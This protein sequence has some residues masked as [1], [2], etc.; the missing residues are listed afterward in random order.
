MLS[1]SVYICIDECEDIAVKLCNISSQLYGIKSR[2]NSN[3]ASLSRACG[4][5]YKS[6]STYYVG[7]AAADL[8]KAQKCVRNAV[9]IYIAV[10]D[11]LS[12][13]DWEKHND[14]TIS[15]TGKIGRISIS[16]SMSD[17]D[18]AKRDEFIRFY[19]FLHTDHM[20]S[21]DQFFDNSAKDGLTSDDIANIKYLAYISEE[22]YHTVFF[23]NIS[24]CK[25]ITWQHSGTPFYGKND[26]K[27]EYGVHININEARTYDGA[28]RQV[29]H[30]IGHQID[31]NIMDW[32]TVEYDEEGTKIGNIGYSTSTDLFDSETE[33]SGIYNVLYSDLRNYLSNYVRCKND[34]LG[35][36][37]LN[38][39]SVE[40]TI[41]AML[42]GRKKW[43][44]LNPY[45]R[46]VYEA[47][48][49]ALETEPA[50]RV[51]GVSDIVGGLTNNTVAGYKFS[52]YAV[53]AGHDRDYWYDGNSPTYNQSSEFF[54]HC[55]EYAMSGQSEK[56]DMIRK[57]FPTAVE[58]LET[59]IELGNMKF[60]YDT[61]E[62]VVELLES[63][64]PK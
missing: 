31:D 7:E 29:F 22:P 20:N 28:Y 1:G 12:N 49:H 60:D 55:M 10:N 58:Q 4:K 64:Q 13:I 33:V 6:K 19:E 26:E 21:I 8:A 39:Q 14:F 46:Q 3:I 32:T 23:N 61:G 43:T 37:K 45:E 53:G 16:T 54:A 50:F 41:E 59:H 2:I 48:K 36:I 47:I 42:D 11:L 38:D 30:E 17:E 40:E 56:L 27:N 52:F 57:V 9:E 25:V 35:H 5:Y 44:T 34:N 62:D 51:Y 18:K 24:N 63:T 15:P